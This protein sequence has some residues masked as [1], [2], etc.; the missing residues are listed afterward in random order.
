MTCRL[1]LRERKSQER[2]GAPLLAGRDSPGWA[3]RGILPASSDG[4]M[5]F[6]MHKD[7]SAV[8]SRG[9][10]RVKQQKVQPEARP[11]AV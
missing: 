10:S 11:T 2:R 4:D 5:C 6:L 7:V 8:H 1:E 3:P 9:N